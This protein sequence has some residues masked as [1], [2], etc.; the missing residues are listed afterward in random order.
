MNFGGDTIQPITEG[1]KTS[2]NNGY[3]ILELVTPIGSIMD[4]KWLKL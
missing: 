3:V 4:V 2:E 1:L